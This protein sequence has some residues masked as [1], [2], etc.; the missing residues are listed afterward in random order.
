MRRWA[1]G[2]DA[3]NT[4]TLQNLQEMKCPLKGRRNVQWAKRPECEMGVGKMRNCGMRKVKCGTDHAENYRGMVC[5]LRN[6]ESHYHSQR[7]YR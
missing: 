4:G 6:A 1:D 2:A 5:N 3:V 7:Q